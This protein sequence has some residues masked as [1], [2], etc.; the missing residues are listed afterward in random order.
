MGTGGQRAKFHFLNCDFFFLD[1]STS[2]AYFIHIFFLSQVA[3]E[4]ENKAAE[5][6]FVTEVGP[7]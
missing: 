6:G 5:N 1:I 7:D 4:V 3:F 2:V